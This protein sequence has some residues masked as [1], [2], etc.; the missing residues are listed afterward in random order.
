MASFSPV[1]TICPGE[2]ATSTTEAFTGDNMGFSIFMASMVQITP[3]SWTVLPTVT[4]TRTIFPGNGASITS[5]GIFIQS[6]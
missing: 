3:P 6:P 1:L 4:S 2:T 5:L